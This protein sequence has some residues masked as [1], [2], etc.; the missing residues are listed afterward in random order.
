MLFRKYCL[1]FEKACQLCIYTSV[2][3][4]SME[5]GTNCHALHEHYPIR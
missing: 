3:S 1:V 5:I 4:I 2:T